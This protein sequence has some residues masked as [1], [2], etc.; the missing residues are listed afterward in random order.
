MPSNGVPRSQCRHTCIRSL[1]NNEK[2][3]ADTLLGPI[4]FCICFSLLNFVWLVFNKILILIFTN[5]TPFNFN[6]SLIVH[7]LEHTTVLFT[8]LLLLSFVN[9]N[10]SSQILNPLKVL[11]L[12]III[13]PCERSE[14]GLY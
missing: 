13:N 5:L 9:I 7:Q 3:R 4:S 1:Q 6:F 10:R 12:Y 2:G 8:P 11:K 14:E